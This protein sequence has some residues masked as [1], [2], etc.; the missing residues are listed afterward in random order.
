M[1]E[2]TDFSIRTDELI[3]EISLVPMLGFLLAFCHES[4]Y[5]FSLGI[6]ARY[7]ISLQ[8]IIRAS[9]LSILP[10]IP[11]ILIGLW[12]G[13]V[14]KP[15][16][17]KS[18]REKAKNFVAL[19]PEKMVFITVYLSAAC[20][21]LLGAAPEL[22]ISFLYLVIIVVVGRIFIFP[23]LRQTGVTS[24]FGIWIIIASLGLFAGMGSSEAYD[25]RSGQREKFPVL[26]ST[27]FSEVADST[28]FVLRS[29]S[30]GLLVGTNDRERVWFLDS[31]TTSTLEFEIDPEPFKGLLCYALDWCWASGWANKPK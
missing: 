4:A 1:S 7:I 26:S 12:L 9:T 28:A 16:P 23:H 31:T 29:F 27:Q 30:S 15:K 22:S 13:S 20:F 6:D 2:T 11:L 19:A 3:K 18:V 17:A 5:F 24:F 25:V 8:D 21:I 10:A 14:P